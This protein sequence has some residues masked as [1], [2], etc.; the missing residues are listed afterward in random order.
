MTT[1]PV[2]NPLPLDKSS[3]FVKPTIIVFVGKAWNCEQA[4]LALQTACAEAINKYASPA[5]CVTSI[6]FSLTQALKDLLRLPQHFAKDSLEET[7]P[8]FGKRLLRLRVALN[9]LAPL[10]L[11]RNAAAT[12]VAL[13]TQGRDVYIT[14]IDML[15]EAIELRSMCGALVVQLTD[16][17]ATNPNDFIGYADVIISGK[18]RFTSPAYMQGLARSGKFSQLAAETGAIAAPGQNLIRLRGNA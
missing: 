17:N 16:D 12:A 13:R 4:V 14:G 1:R 5:A 10:S 9:D 8:D 15:A 7:A 3:A 11:A 2:L 6:P 18:E